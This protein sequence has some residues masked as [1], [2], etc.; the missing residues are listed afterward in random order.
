VA[1]RTFIDNVANF[2]IEQCFIDGMTEIL[3]PKRI[4]EM[5]DAQVEKLAAESDNTIEYRKHKM[6]QR[7]ELQDALDMCRMASYRAGHGT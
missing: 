5:S 2:A 7:Q 3:T 6:K 4:V 1:L